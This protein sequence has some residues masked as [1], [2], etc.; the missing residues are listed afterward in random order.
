MS[1]ANQHPYTPNL[2]KLFY[3]IGN[4][5]QFP[6]MFDTKSLDSLLSRLGNSKSYPPYDIIS[7]VDEENKVYEM[8]VKMALAGFDKEDINIEVKSNILTV[9][10]AGKTED[11]QDYIHKGISKRAFETKFKL[12][13]HALVKEAIMD[14]GILEVVIEFIIPEDKKTSKIFI[15]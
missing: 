13:Q 6:S 2:D 9:S 7:N 1:Q 4:G 11:K 5:T 14:N 15:K 12:S 8:S 10:S 3:H